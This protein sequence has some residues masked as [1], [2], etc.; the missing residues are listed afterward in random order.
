MDYTESE[1]LQYIAE[2][3]VKFIKLFFIDIYGG[4]K[5]VSIMPSEL[6]RAFKTGISFDASSVPGFSGAEKSDLFILPDPSTLSIL[7]WRPQHGRVVRFYS[8]I[9]Y[10]DGSP[11]ECDT[12]YL[13]QQTAAKAE[14]LGYNIKIGTECEFYLFQLDEKGYPTLIPHD[15]AGYCDLAPRDKGENVRR[16]ICLT[17]EQMGLSPEVSHHESGPGQHEVDFKYSS[18]VKSADNLSTFKTVV[19]TIAARSGLYASFMPKPFCSR[20]ALD[21]VLP[22]SFGRDEKPVDYPGSG[23]HVNISLYKNGHNSILSDP[24]DEEAKSFIAGILNRIV[25]ITAFL[26][27]LHNS[28]DR[29]GKLEA[30]R[31]VSWSRQNRSQL[32]R[33]PA[34]HGEDARIELRSPDPACNQYTALSLIVHAGLEGIQKKLELPEPCSK[35]LFKLSSSE[36][37]KYKTL[38]LTL[39]QALAE[40]RKSDFVKAV[41]PAMLTDTFFGMK[42]T[43]RDPAF[44]EL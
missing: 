11:C 28:Y 2:N 19:K 44:E 33:I 37:A 5:S 42:K 25:D 3:D 20:E 40:A 21:G 4:L 6:E 30:P 1:V 34:A 35:N 8:N 13:L 22:G 9:R 18:L 36:L 27:P 32:I 16:D 14:K 29:L 43:G 39:P 12:R 38:P 24:M 23:L 26:N 10:P 7:P 41:L 17:L 15:R 31:C